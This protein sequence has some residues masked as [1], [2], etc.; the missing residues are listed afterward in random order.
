MM[1]ARL[2]GCIA[3]GWIGVAGGATSS[4]AISGTSKARIRCAFDEFVSRT[5]DPALPTMNVT[6]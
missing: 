5:G 1:Y 4:I 6:R 3:T 2:P